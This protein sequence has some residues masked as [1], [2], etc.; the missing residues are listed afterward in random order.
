M[1]D[2]DKDPPVFPMLC[3]TRGDEELAELARQSGLSPAAA[4]AVAAIDT[5]MA[6]MRRSMQRRE[7]GRQVLALMG[8][9]LD[10]THLDAIITIGVTTRSAPDD[11][12]TV[13]LLAERMG[14]DPSRASRI[15]SE[16]VERGYARRVASQADARR[17]CLE[18]T[19][20][21]RNLTDAIRVNKWRLF[22]QSLSQWSEADLV[23][24][25]ALF[26]KFSTWA[27]D[28]DGVA[29]SAEEI[30]RRIDEVEAR[31]EEKVD[32]G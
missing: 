1:R 14:I 11:E 18:L 2:E 24:F 29:R 30:K 7:F 31:H 32:A 13:G 6:R 10:V 4:D 12:M 22:A 15:A 26:E 21:G 19:D 20:R 3:Q 27:T 17:I 16:V 8:S 28:R 9:D 23:T 5:I 25:A